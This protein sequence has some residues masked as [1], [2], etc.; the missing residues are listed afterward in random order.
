MVV[1]KR[2]RCPA[3]GLNGGMLGRRASEEVY[4]AL[5]RRSAALPFRLARNSRLSVRAGGHLKWL[6]CCAPQDGGQ[7]RTH[8]R[9]R[10]RLRAEL[11]LR[12]GRLNTVRLSRLHTRVQWVQTSLSQK[13]RLQQLFFPEGVAFDG[14]RFNRTAATAPFFKY[15]APSESAEEG[16]V[17]QEGIEPS[18]RR[19]RVCC[20]AN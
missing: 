14:N 16:L 11:Q 19:L 1:D 4:T 6:S 13:Q 18:T 2:T 15:L 3:T 20:S 9:R 8:D 10:F 5:V 7:R 17:S 12:D